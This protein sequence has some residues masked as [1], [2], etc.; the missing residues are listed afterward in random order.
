MLV[1]VDSNM[2]EDEIKAANPE[3]LPV[4]EVDLNFDPHG[5]KI[6]DGKIVAKNNFDEYLEREAIYKTHLKFSGNETDTELDDKIN[7]FFLDQ[8]KDINTWK[9][10]NY[11]F[12]RKFFYPDFNEYID[13]QVK[14]HSND[15][16]LQQDGQNQLTNYF[17]KCQAIKT[18]FPKLSEIKV[19]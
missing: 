14:I 18:R 13:A 11:D 7:S 19:E 2:I 15:T 16:K 1:L 5:H 8:I 6:V 3:K 10:E 9:K 4:I 17:Q 12:L